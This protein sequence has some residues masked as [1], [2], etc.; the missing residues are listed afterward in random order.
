MSAEERAYELMLRAYPRAFRARY[1]QQMMLVFRD[2]RREQGSGVRFWSR[3]LWDTVRSAPVLRLEMWR[4]QWGGDTYSNGGRMKTMAILAVVIGAVVALNS[5]IEGWA[6]GV[7]GH[8]SSSL[9]VGALGL[10]AGVGVLIAGVALL[11]GSR[12]AAMLAQGAAVVCLGVFALVLG[13]SPRFSI[14]ADILGIGFPI[15]LLL[16]VRFAGGRGTPSARTA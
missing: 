9:A 7:V 5:S 16:F 10:L 14:F 12:S 1:A 6:G 11:R 2:L 3:M 15:A 4:T 8:D 13:V